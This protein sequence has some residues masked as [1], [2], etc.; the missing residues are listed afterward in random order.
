M[1]K[2]AN[3]RKRLPSERHSQILFWL[4][5][6]L[7]LLLL[8]ALT[9]YN[10]LQYGRN[11]QELSRFEKSLNGGDYQAAE[12]WYSSEI[13][14]NPAL[15][16]KAQA[17]LVQRIEQLKLAYAEGR[18]TA[19]AYQEALQAMGNWGGARQKAILALNGD[20]EPLTRSKEAYVQAKQAEE[21]GHIQ[22]AIQ[23]YQ[24]VL[25]I[26]P[27]YEE[28][29]RLL[30][31]LQAR[32]QRNQENALSAELSSGQLTAA[33]QRLEEMKTVLGSRIDLQNWQLRISQAKEEKAWH[34]AKEE[35]Q[36]AIRQGDWQAVSKALQHLSSLAGDQLER[37]QTYVGLKNAMLEELLQRFDFLLQT[38][39]ASEAKDLLQVAREAFPGEP[40][41]EALWHWQTGRL[42]S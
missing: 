34:Q 11:P 33:E 30:A 5:I 38:Q 18:L 12:Q 21:A 39:R 9:A 31:L 15:E 19:Q 1:S 4:G 20:L 23:A 41:L 36:T 28:V 2:K 27:H 35:A 8:F 6:G 3:T 25:L 29:Q 24:K 14:G 42:R 16:I 40:L 13:R 26:D 22:E 7:M 17:L 37:W 32:Y 10:L